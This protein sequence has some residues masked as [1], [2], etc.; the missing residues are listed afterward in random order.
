MTQYVGFC[1]FGMYFIEKSVR[2]VSKDRRHNYKL[3][4]KDTQCIN[5]KIS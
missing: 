2:G 1:R 5:N 3:M 4:S